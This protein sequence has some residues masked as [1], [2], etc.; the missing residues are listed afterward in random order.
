MSKYTNKVK[1]ETEFEGDKI[2]ATLS[3]LK[4]KDFLKM[5]P[6]M[7]RDDD[8]NSAMTEEDEIKFMSIA[9]DILPGYVVTFYGLVDNDGEVIEFT[10]VCNEVYFMSLTSLFVNKLFEISNMGKDI[11]IKNSDVQQEIHT[12]E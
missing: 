3:R 9:S 10:T 8:G 1:F 7:K 4:R 2:T 5:L 6:Y 11:E 12:T